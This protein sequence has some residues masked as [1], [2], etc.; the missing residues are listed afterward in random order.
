MHIWDVKIKDIMKDNNHPMDDLKKIHQ[1]VINAAYEII[2]K[3][4]INILWNWYGS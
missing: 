4:E 3:K 2:D 1:G